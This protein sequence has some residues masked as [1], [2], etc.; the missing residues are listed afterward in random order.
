MLM[1]CETARGTSPTGRRRLTEIFSFGSA[2]TPAV[3]PGSVQYGCRSE[4]TG[5]DYR[6][7]VFTPPG[8]APEAGYL[9]LYVVDETRNLFGRAAV[10]F[11]VP[12]GDN[13]RS[14][15]LEWARTEVS[16]RDQ[17]K[18]K[19]THSSRTRDTPSVRGSRWWNKIVELRPIEHRYGRTSNTACN[20]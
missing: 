15:Q 14:V 5:R 9:V 10:Q 18:V 6:I 16:D 3:V 7:S 2:E 11:V 13:F 20:Q 1:D 8:L 19:L 12:V 4:S 17:L